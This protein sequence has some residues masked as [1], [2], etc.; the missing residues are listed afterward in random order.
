MNEFMA[1]EKNAGRDEQGALFSGRCAS[2]LA[3]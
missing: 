2:Q 1:L 3:L